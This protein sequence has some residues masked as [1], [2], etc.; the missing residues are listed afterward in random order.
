MNNKSIYVTFIDK[1]LQSEFESLK[2]GKFQDKK[3]YEFMD[4]AIKDLK[5]DPTSGTK[6]Q[7]R[8]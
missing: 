1:K 8:I 5:K 2:K 3:L 4:R 7:K 6:I